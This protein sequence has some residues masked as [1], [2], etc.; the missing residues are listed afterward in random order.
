MIKYCYTNKIKQHLSTDLCKKSTKKLNAAY[1]L[2]LKITSF[3]V[4]IKDFNYLIL[5]VIFLM[6]I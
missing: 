6:K 5:K 4:K 1:W 3:Y 2:W